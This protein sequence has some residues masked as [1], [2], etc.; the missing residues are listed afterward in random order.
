MPTLY[1]FFANLL[2]SLIVLL[3]FILF[4]LLGKS[5]FQWTVQI[6]KVTFQAD[7]KNLIYLCRIL[8]VSNFH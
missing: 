2:H 1:S 4:Y 7:E 8:K 6:L 3:F 5:L